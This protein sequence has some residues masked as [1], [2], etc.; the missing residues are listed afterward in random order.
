MSFQCRRRGSSYRDHSSNTTISLA[1]RGAKFNTIISHPSNIYTKQSLNAR[2]VRC[3]ASYQNRYLIPSTIRCS[4]SYCMFIL[5]LQKKKHCMAIQKC[6]S[7][8]K[9]GRKSSRTYVSGACI[10]QPAHAHIYT[11]SN[12]NT[13]NGHTLA[14]WM[15]MCGAII[16]PIWCAWDTQQARTAHSQT[17]R[18]TSAHAAPHRTPMPCKRRM[19]IWIGN[20]EKCTA[21]QNHSILERSTRRQQ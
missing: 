20:K 10:E 13:P 4:A 6:Q 9:H 2:S 21:G 15:R 1:G 19:N 3:G 14:L 8:C 7:I 12:A 18:H 5:R 11:L 17:H 16:L